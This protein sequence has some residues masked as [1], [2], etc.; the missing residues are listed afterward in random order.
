MSI[1]DQNAYMNANDISDEENLLEDDDEQFDPIERVENYIALN[2]VMAVGGAFLTGVII[3][4]LAFALA[5]R[6]D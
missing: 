6:R 5:L 2:P 3:G 1:A 4:G